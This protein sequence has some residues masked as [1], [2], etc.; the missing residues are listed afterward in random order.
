MEKT[1]TFV[2]D[3][4]EVKVTQVS[5]GVKLS[6]DGMPSEYIK[7]IDGFWCYTGGK[8]LNVNTT[9]L[10]SMINE[11]VWAMARSVRADQKAKQEIN[12][13]FDVHGVDAC[14]E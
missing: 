1:K 6:C 5:V 3:G 14:Q 9:S 2:H 13:W 7:P 12:D 10:T 8:L 11:A 4:V